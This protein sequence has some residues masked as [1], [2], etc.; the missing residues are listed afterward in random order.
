MVFKS[1]IRYPR[2]GSSYCDFID[3]GWLLSKKAGCFRLYA[4]KIEVRLSKLLWSIQWSVAT[5]NAPLSQFLCDLILCWYVLHTPD[6]NGYTLDSSAGSWPQQM[7]FTL[8]G[9]IFT[10]F[11]SYTLTDTKI[12]VNTSV[13]TVC[14]T[15]TISHRNSDKKLILNTQRYLS[16]LIHT[17]GRVMNHYW[18]KGII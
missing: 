13:I 3:R 6:M 4:W 8:L 7:K 10:H 11:R 2:V 15:T 12:E 14:W 9:L 16:S 5:Y 1:L 18:Y 17:G